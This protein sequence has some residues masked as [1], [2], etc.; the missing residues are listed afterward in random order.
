MEKTQPD[1]GFTKVSNEILEALARVK[2]SPTQYRLLFVIW[3]Y[4]FG[5]NREEHDLSLS[6]LSEATGCDKRQ[7]QRELKSLEGRSIIYQKIKNGSYRIIGFVSDPSH[8]ASIGETINARVDDFTNGSIDSFTNQERNKEKS[9]EKDDRVRNLNPFLE[10]EKS[11]GVLPGGIFKE[12]IIYWM[13]QSNFLEPEAIICEVIQ[14]AKMNTPKNPSRYITKIIS[15]L[16]DQ[17]LF[18]LEAV[19]QY[20]SQFDQKVNKQAV[21]R[22]NL[23]VSK[24]P[25]NL[26][27]KR[28]SQEEWHQIKQLEDDLPY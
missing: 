20:N 11:F 5:F 28:L 17:G 23:D 22:A 15:N 19:Q 16:H 25:E 13:D 4:T 3:R 1:K 18:T 7:I 10:Y 9:K 26:E 27:I 24:V 2:L 8:W 21:K 12:E 14:R 6:F